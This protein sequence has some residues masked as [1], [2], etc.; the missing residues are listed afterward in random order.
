MYQRD[1]PTELVTKA[2]CGIAAR[3]ENSPTVGTSMPISLYYRRQEGT[4]L[5]GVGGRIDLS[6]PAEAFGGDILLMTVLVLF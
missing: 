5:Y 3:S 2:S 4:G 6:A 1:F